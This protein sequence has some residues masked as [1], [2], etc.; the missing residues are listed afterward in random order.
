MCGVTA[1]IA[2]NTMITISLIILKIDFE[3]LIKFIKPCQWSS[4]VNSKPHSSS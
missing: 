4:T 3:A 2:G 1:G